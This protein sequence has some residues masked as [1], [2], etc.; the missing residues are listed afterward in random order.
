[1]V[2][3]HAA[4]WPHKK[5]YGESLDDILAVRFLNIRSV[6]ESAE[7]TRERIRH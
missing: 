4:I 2:T 1:M 7:L 3:F 6:T 5:K